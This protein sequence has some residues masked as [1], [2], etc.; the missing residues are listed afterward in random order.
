MNLNS[1]EFF[2][3]RDDASAKDVEIAL[4]K[5]EVASLTKERD[6]WKARALES[7]A[8]DGT[9]KADN[10]NFIMISVQRLKAVA[11]KI[12]DVHLLGALSF[13]LQKALPEP[14][15]AN[16]CMAINN[17]IPLPQ[18]DQISLSA[19]GDIVLRKETNIDI[20]KNYGPN[21]DVHDGG[22]ID[23]AG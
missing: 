1:D 21:V 4:L 8:E 13:I 16:D 2:L 7:G 20:D 14:A 9:K 12:H 17:C 11:S 22:V 19:Q 15:G 6:L 23:V 18:P 3:L 5:K 10:R